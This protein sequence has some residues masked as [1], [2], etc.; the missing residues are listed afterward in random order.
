MSVLYTPYSCS[1]AAAIFF[2]K[3]SGRMSVQTSLM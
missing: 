3:L 2:L 1:F